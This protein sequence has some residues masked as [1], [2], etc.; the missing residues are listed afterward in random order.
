MIHVVVL[1]GGIFGIGINDLWTRA[2]NPWQA[3][4][5]AL[6]FMIA[7]GL[8]AQ[9]AG[10]FKDKCGSLWERIRKPKSEA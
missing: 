5:G 9:V 10:P 4:T 1:Y 6:L 2:L 7:F 8:M 3:A